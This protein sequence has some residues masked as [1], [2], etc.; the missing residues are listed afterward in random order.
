MGARISRP[1]Q[2]ACF[3]D[4]RCQSARVLAAS[5]G[6]DYNCEMANALTAL[7]T[8][9]MLS[10]FLLGFSSGLPLLLIGSTL[11]AWMT[12]EKIDL[13][14]VGL[15][16][17][18]Q[19]PYS[20][21]FLWAPL[22]DR[23]TLPLLD[24]RRGWILV[25]QLALMVSIFAISFFHPATDLKSLTI[26]C[27][28]VAFF[29]ASQ[30]IAIDAYRREVLRDEE[31]G[32][33]ASFGVNG[34][35]IGMLVAGA[36]ALALA[37]FLSWEAS[38]RIM[39]IGMGVAI[40]ATLL[41][42]SVKGDVLA[43]RNLTEAVVQPFLEFFS[44]GFAVEVLVFILL[45][46][47]GDQM[48]SDMFNPFY[49]QMGYTKAE[50]AAISKVFGLWA[51]IAGGFLGG[52]CLVRYSLKSCLWVFGS[53]Q[54]VSTLGFSWLATFIGPNLGALTTVVTVEN[55]CS[56]LGSAAYVAFMALLTDR[57]FT[58]TQYALLSSLMSVPRIFFGSSTGYLAQAMG[59]TPYFVFCAAIGLP[60]LL[61]LVRFPKWT[62]TQ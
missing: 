38:Y 5:R 1:F 18:V 31:Q 55:L 15:F 9:R 46:K 10:V 49:I 52:L 3:I 14:T 60:G 4:T 25:F 48:A 34:Y 54:I 45:F 36:G 11:K 21:K 41:A 44:R 12:E 32:L 8:R 33:G 6:F 51:T 47:L 39:G 53:L 43:P 29:A 57:R 20:L 22:L 28:F 37:Q 35:R 19:L 30:D 58:A 23:Y 42:P 40:F 61:M 59:W 16:A 17:L 7:F 56:G 24:R 13:G 27:V 50:I 2:N 62:K 26:A